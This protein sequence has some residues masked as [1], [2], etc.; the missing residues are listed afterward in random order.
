MQS[1]FYGYIYLLGDGLYRSQV[2][3]DVPGHTGEQCL[4]FVFCFFYTQTSISLRLSNSI[5]INVVYFLPGCCS[6]LYEVM[7]DIVNFF[8]D[9][10]EEKDILH[11]AAWK[12]IESGFDQCCSTSNG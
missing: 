9:G 11:G 4:V 5:L 6:A 10:G 1:P 12:G 7:L 8:K 3:E 2:G